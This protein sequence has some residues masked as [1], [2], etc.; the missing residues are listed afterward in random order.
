M[1]AEEYTASDSDTSDS[2]SEFE[3][4]SE[5]EGSTRPRKCKLDDRQK[6]YIEGKSRKA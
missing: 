6:S 4:T 5:S 1:E 3:L 2:S